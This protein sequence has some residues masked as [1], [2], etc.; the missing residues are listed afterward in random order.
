MTIS[1]TPMLATARLSTIGITVFERGW[2]SSNNVLFQ[3]KESTA[4]VDSGYCTHAEQTVALVQDALQ[5]RPLDLL[6]NTHLHSDHCG[7]N[8]SLQSNW[9]HLTTLIPPGQ[10]GAV[11]HWDSVALSHEPTGQTCPVFKFQNVLAPGDTIELGDLPWEIH[12]A[13]GHD[14]HSIVLFEPVSR[15]LIS[16]D[17][18]WENG[19]GVV[20]PELEDIAAFDEVAD[21]LSLIQALNPITVI[22]GHGAVFEDV[23][24]ALQRARS[25][26]NQFVANPEQHRRYALKV[27]LKFKLLEWQSIGFGTLLDWYAR[28]PYISQIERRR[29]PISPEEMEHSLHSLISELAKSHALRVEGDTIVNI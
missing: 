6:L 17:A 13:K 26:L 24:L 18:L 1:G 23:D 19:F 16:A 15:T 9:P 3:G 21:T 4:L 14:P 25:R 11:A 22:P 28:T 5:T 29:E 10:A 20:F 8:A 2:L 12:A 27:L 7:G